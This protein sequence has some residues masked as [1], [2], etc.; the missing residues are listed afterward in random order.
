MNFEEKQLKEEYDDE[1][2][3]EVLRTVLNK[4]K[5]KK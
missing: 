3:A 5:D 4:D 2:A 1:D